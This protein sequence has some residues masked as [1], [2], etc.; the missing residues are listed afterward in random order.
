MIKIKYI[1]PKTLRY[2]KDGK[3][4]VGDLFELRFVHK[5]NHEKRFKLDG[6]LHCDCPSRVEMPELEPM[7]KSHWLL[8]IIH[9]E[10]AEFVEGKENTKD[11]LLQYFF[12]GE[13][14]LFPQKRRLAVALTLGGRTKVHVVYLYMD[15]SSSS[16]GHVDI[17]W[18]TPEKKNITNYELRIHLPFLWNETLQMWNV[19]RQGDTC[20]IR[21]V[22]TPD[23]RWYDEHMDFFTKQFKSH[24]LSHKSG[25]ETFI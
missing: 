6:F 3:Q 16:M 8:G 12:Q 11:Y 20:R 13:S 23:T 10:L 4:Q 5:N 7:E 17:R 22:Y 2:R 24:L 14:P 25:C 19:Y 15:K 1:D 21:F 18:M 9:D